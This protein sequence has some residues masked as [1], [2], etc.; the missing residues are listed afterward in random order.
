MRKLFFISI[1]TLFACSNLL[2]QKSGPNTRT[3]ITKMLASIA[4]HKGYTYTMEGQERIIGLD[5]PKK[6][7]VQV[8]LMNSPLKVY[9]K[10]MEGKR[11]DTE[12]LYV[13]DERENNAIVN[14]GRFV[15][16]LTLS[17]IGDNLTEDQR[18]TIFELGFAYTGKIINELMRI[19]DKAKKFDT[20]F[21]AATPI[22]QNGRNCYK[23]TITNMN[24]DYTSY[25]AS[26]GE[27]AFSIAQKL[28]IP[29]YSILELN[30]H[31]KMID[32]DLG[33]RTLRVQ[34]GYARRC[35]L[36]IDKETYLPIFQEMY[37]DSGVFEH[38]EFTDIII[39]P[40]FKANEFSEENSDYKF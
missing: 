6:G 2:A 5:K 23:I 37:D 32:Q 34:I 4:A 31:I 33:G 28:M 9:V 25:K 21:S 12:I 18:H 7:S 1:C 11:K 36:Y 8:K 22:V 38:Y 26:K 17:P 27:N 13:K 39:N 3:I 10:L 29:T 35:I 14:I 16:N 19:T 24:W 40:A 15:P 30:D 20:Y